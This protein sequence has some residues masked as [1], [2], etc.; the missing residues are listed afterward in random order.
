MN[1][2]WIQH[3][4]VTLIQKQSIVTNNNMK[5]NMKNHGPCFVVGGMVIAGSEKQT[6]DVGHRKKVQW[7]TR[8]LVA[9]I[10]ACCALEQRLPGRRDAEFRALCSVCA[11]WCK[12][13]PQHLGHMRHARFINGPPKHYLRGFLEILVGS[14]HSHVQ[15]HS[16]ST[17][18]GERTWKIRRNDLPFFASKNVLCCF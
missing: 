10:F 9:G 14:W 5:T 3:Q 16:C 8:R 7:R 2:A 1:L 11:V 15:P 13:C 17:H 18:A 6:W 4:P 12:S